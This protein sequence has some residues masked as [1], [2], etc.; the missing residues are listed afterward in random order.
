[1]PWIFVFE[2]KYAVRSGREGQSNRWQK[3]QHQMGNNLGFTY[4]VLTSFK[5]R[6]R[7]HD[8]SCIHS[9]HFLNF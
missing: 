2:R 5:M 4:V 9:F 8:F 1:M 3:S 7:P 6:V